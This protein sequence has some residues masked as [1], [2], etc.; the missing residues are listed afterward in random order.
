[1]P[2]TAMPRNG[3]AVAGNGY[4]GNK[5]PPKKLWMVATM[6]ALWKI[7]YIIDIPFYIEYSTTISTLRYTGY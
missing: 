5:E 3:N 1:M 7:N 4:Y 2:I 6:A